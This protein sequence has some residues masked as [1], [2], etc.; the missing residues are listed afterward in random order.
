M[1]NILWPYGLQYARLPCPSP[2]PGVYSDSCPL[3]QWCYLTI[4]S[5]TTLFSFCL[6]SVLASGTFPLSQLFASGGRG[7][8]ASALVLP[9]NI[10]YW[11][12]LGLT[13]LISLLS[14]DSQ[15]SSPTIQNHQ[16]FR[17]SFCGHQLV[18]GYI[19]RKTG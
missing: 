10:Q 17:T 12:P 14:K 13:G 1:S 18:V 15:E 3:S 2:S 11:F 8:G 5:S 9:M 19:S 6:Q 4:S 16:F 7:I